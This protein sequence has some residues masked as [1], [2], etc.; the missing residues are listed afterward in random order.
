MAHGVGPKFK[1]VSLCWHTVARLH[2]Q[3]Q[4]EPGGRLVPWE[5][6]LSV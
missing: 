3:G 1:G 2:A 6:M 4:V 5:G